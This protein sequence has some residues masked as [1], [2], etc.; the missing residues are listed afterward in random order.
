MRTFFII[1]FAILSIGFGVAFLLH[2]GAARLPYLELSA[3]YG[4]WAD[5]V[6]REGK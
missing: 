1:A 3:L 4:I 6:P 2:P 5:I